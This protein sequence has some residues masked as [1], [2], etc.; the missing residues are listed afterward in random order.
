M[1]KAK[2]Q[3]FEFL[4]ENMSF[5]ITKLSS[6]RAEDLME[7]M[8]PVQYPNYFLYFLCI[9]DIFGQFCVSLRF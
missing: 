7:E 6:K 4:K 3:F 2:E 1:S 9:Q 8:K 5:V